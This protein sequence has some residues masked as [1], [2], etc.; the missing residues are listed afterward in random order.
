MTVF[1]G[2]FAVHDA[3]NRPLL[4]INKVNIAVEYDEALR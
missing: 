2:G 4:T 3:L 1:S